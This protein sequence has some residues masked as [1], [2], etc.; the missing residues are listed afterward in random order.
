M[1][2]YKEQTDEVHEI[3]LESKIVVAEW[4]QKGAAVGEQVKLE[5]VTHFVGNGS[6]IEIKVEDKSGKKVQ[7]VTGHVYGEY[8]AGSIVIP[9]KAK[10]ELTFTAKLSDHSLELKSAILIIVPPR[11]ITNAKW[12]QLEARRGDVVK[13]TADT[14]N[15]PDDTEVMISIYEHDQD[16]AH[17]FITK[18]PAKVKQNKIEAEWEYEYHEDTDEIP[19]HAELQPIG[20]GYNPPEYFFRLTVGEMTAESGLIRFQDWVEFTV[21]DSQ[22]NPIGD[23]SFNITFADGRKEN[24]RL[25]SKGYAKIHSVPPGSYVI[26]VEGVGQLAGETEKP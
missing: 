17:D 20:K 18:F 2:E 23:R 12:G 1:A 10:D 24:G 15:I 3:E 8:F 14:K 6:K 22:G 19:T 7:T 9:D 13:L 11:K 5:V 4:G 25:D 26:E 21:K 16:G